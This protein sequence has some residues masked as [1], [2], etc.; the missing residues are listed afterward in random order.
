EAGAIRREHLVDQDQFA[1]GQCAPLELGVS[2]DDAAAASVLGGAAVH[3][4]AALLQ[5][6][7]DI[8]PG[9]FGHLLKGNVLVVAAL[10]LGGRRE[11]R[12]GQLLARAQPH[13]QSDAANGAVP[14]ILL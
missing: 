5:C 2:D 13:R 3:V 14:A 10:L 4:N 7:G 1:A 12:L 11:D 6:A 8:G 9:D